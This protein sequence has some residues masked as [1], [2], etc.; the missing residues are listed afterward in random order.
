MRAAIHPQSWNLY[1][2]ALNN[3]VVYTDPTGNNAICN[4]DPDNFVC[5]GNPP[6]PPQDPLGRGDIVP[7]VVGLDAYGVRVGESRGVAD[8]RADTGLFGAS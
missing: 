4:D 7:V 8:R 2:Y 3:P 5:T 1:S 6:P